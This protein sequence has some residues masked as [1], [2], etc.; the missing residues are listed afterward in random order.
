MQRHRA[1]LMTSIS[2]PRCVRPGEGQNPHLPGDTVRYMD[3]L[4]PESVVV[5]SGRPARTADAPL[6]PPIVLSAPFHHGVDNRYLRVES[7]ETIRSFEAA[8][9][10]LE[11]GE[12][13]AFA[14]GMAA[15]AA[16]VEGQPAGSVAVAPAA[17]YGGTSLLF[18]E[19]VRLGRMTVREVDI[20]DTTATVA[21]LTDADLIWVESPTNPLLGVADLPPIVEA[22][23]YRRRHGVRR[24]DLQYPARRPDRSTSARTSSCMPRPRRWPA[25]PI[26]SWACSVTRSPERAE[27]LRTR[28]IRT[29]AMPGALECYLALRGLR[30]LAVRMERAQAQRHAA[31][32]PSS[33]STRGSRGSATRVC[34]PTRFTSGRR[35]CIGATER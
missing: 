17:A 13:I 7:S 3:G 1:I 4:Q 24:L 11:G 33:A 26:S 22:A 14:S 18:A 23:A 10:A 30:T 5:A 35:G 27:A 12:A 6:N 32:R 31:R 34:R 29:G 28:R 15:A 25:T 19:Q 8:V 2:W 9:G 21:A 16:V 20:T